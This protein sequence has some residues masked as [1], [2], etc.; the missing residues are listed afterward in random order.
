MHLPT[1][2]QLFTEP[3]NLLEAL[4]DTIKHEWRSESSDAHKHRPGDVRERP[5][6]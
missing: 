4:S 2:H 5:H 3:L 6:L 1:C